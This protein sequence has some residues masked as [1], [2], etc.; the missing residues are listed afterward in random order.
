MDL[1]AIE[2]KA[3]KSKSLLED[4]RFKETVEDLREMQFRIFADSSASEVEKREDAHAILRALTEIERLL[5]ANVDAVTLITKKGSTVEETNP[6]NGNDLGS[7][8]ENLIMETPK[9]PE[10]EA[11]EV[12]EATEDTQTEAIEDAEVVEDADDVSDIEEEIPDTE[13][14]EELEPTVEPETYGESRWTG[15]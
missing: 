6:I 5:N 9:N 14:I 4:E 8:A 7:V 15:T 2:L 1:A 10:P 12:V 11:E 13:D 3:K